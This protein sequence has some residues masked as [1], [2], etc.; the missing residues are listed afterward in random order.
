MQPNRI[1]NS[2]QFKATLKY[3]AAARKARKQMK[4]TKIWNLCILRFFVLFYVQS[5]DTKEVH[6]K[7]YPPYP[8]PHSRISHQFSFVQACKLEYIAGCIWFWWFFLSGIISFVAYF[9]NL[10]SEYGNCAHSAQFVEYVGSVYFMDTFIA[11]AG[12][13]IF[14]IFSYFSLYIF[15]YKCKTATFL[16]EKKE[17][18]NMVKLSE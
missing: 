10:Q 12:M 2:Q 18:L 8:N 3:P 4:Y 13:H 15:L 17:V 16:Y 9:F 14:I 5:F 1:I 7:N 11:F 6:I